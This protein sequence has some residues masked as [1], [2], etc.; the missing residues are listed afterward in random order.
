MQEKRKA[1]RMVLDV[2]WG[3]VYMALGAFIFIAVQFNAAGEFG[4]K[5]GD[6]LK[7]V[8]GL[9]G[10]VLPWYLILIGLL[11]MPTR[12]CIFLQRP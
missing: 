2:I 3:L 6:I 1:S 7:G 9:I 10:L 12:Q 5:M 11:L 8:F 4:N